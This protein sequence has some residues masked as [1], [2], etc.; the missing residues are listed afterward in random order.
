[1]PR[2]SVI[3]P[4][5]NQ[6][7]FVEEAVNSVLAQT[8]DDFEII[9]VNDGSTDALTNQ[10]LHAFNR[11]RTTVLHTDNQGLGPAR[12]YGIRAGSGEYVLPLDA[13]DRI[14]ATYLEKAV[15]ILEHNPNTGIVYS[16]AAF[17]G[18]R[19]GLWKLK[20]YRFPDILLEN[21]IFATAMFR[22]SDWEATGGYRADFALWEDYEFWLSIIELK[23]DVYRIPE[24]LF[25][26]RK[27]PSSKTAVTDVGQLSHAHAQIWR[28]HAALFNE[29]L[30]FVASEL[31][32]QRHRIADLEA[33]IGAMT[34]SMFWRARA[35][36]HRIFS[37]LVRRETDWQAE[38]T[39]KSDHMN[40]PA[41]SWRRQHS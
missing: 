11:P 32:R 25:F 3:I 6:G 13:D 30:P 19:S 8:F 15:Q 31:R 10:I 4:C 17:F 24:V 41:T 7:Q 12:N 5:Y 36:L 39:F 21:V 9:I 18:A 33:T 1:M 16:E 34:G 14:G 37:A 26:Y 40:E 35:A 23:R 29:H 2:V 22:R 38:V 27:H 20:P 28:T